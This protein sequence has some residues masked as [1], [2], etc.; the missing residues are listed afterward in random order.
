MSKKLIRRSSRE[1]LRD[2]SGSNSKTMPGS[3]R[4]MVH[5]VRNG[6]KLPF[7]ALEPGLI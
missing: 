4:W 5:K 7:E 3:G 1:A 6:G 2:G